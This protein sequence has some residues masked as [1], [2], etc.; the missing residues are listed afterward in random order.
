LTKIETNYFILS[1]EQYEECYPVADELGIN[2][3]YYL[4]EFCSVE[5]S[6]VITD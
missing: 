1:Q 6:Y 2:L 4:M 3:D 5:G